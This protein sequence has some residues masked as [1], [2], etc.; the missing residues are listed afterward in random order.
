[1]LMIKEVSGID[2]GNWIV[3]YVSFMFIAPGNLFSTTLM[4]L[5]QIDL[6]LNK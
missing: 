6:S 5:Y 3:K 1:M 2:T 4:H